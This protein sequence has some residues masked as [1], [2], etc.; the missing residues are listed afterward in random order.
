VFVDDEQV[1]AVGCFPGSPTGSDTMGSS[2][3]LLEWLVIL[4]VP[5]GVVALALVFLIGT[6]PLQALGWYRGAGV[7]A[8]LCLGVAAWGWAL[9]TEKGMA[10]A[11]APAV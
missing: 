10:A 8:V 11:A 9:W 6:G 2:S 5:L 3:R 7:G 1:F 4:T